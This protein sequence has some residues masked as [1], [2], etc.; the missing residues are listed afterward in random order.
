MERIDVL[1]SL[2]TGE[3]DWWSASTCCVRDLTYPSVAF[4][5]HPRRRQGSYL[6]AFG[7]SSRSSAGGAQRRGHVVMYATRSRFDAPAS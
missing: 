2:R 4:H 5:R 3:V 7:R 6:R 1:R